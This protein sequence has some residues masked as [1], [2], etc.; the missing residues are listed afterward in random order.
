MSDKIIAALLAGSISLIVSLSITWWRSSVEL[1][2]LKQEIE[3]QYA[4]KLFEARLERYP[5]LYSYVSSFAKL[6][7][8]NQASLDDLITLKN[9]VDKWDS[10]NA[11]L[12]NSNSVRIMYRLRKLLYAYTE[13][14][15]PLCINDRKNIKI[16]IMA[17]ESSIKYEVGIH[18]INPLGKIKNEDIVHNSLDELIQAVKESS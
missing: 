13:R 2:K 4:S 8:K 3:H 15:T 10:D 1:K 7:E 6:L 11:L 5:S 17:I 14:N 16:A 18:D 9:Q 12:L